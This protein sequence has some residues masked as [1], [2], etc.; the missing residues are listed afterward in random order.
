MHNTPQNGVSAIVIPHPRALACKVQQPRSKGNY[1]QNVIFMHDA[2]QKIAFLQVQHAKLQRC[3]DLRTA[4]RCLEESTNGKPTTTSLQV[5]ERFG[6]RHDNVLRAIESLECSK[7]FTDLN[8]EVSAY[9]DS[10]GRCHPRTQRSF[11]C[12][13]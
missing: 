8:F 9:T 6:K 13:K 2:R 5:A 11:P 12:L 4:V 10:T 1:P 7:E 3:A